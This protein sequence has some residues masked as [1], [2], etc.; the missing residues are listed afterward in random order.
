MARKSRWRFWLLAIV[1]IDAVCLLG[2]WA[3]LPKNGIRVEELKTDLY[4]A[5][6]PTEHPQM[7]RTGLFRMESH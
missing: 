5:D 4:R 6:F 2:Y 1:V 7:W 3:N